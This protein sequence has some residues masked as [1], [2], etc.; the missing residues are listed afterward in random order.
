MHPSYLKCSCDETVNHLSCNYIV[1]QKA[2]AN[3]DVSDNLSAPEGG[4][5]A[6]MQAV[7]CKQQIGWR[8]QAR[9]LLVVSADAGFHYAQDRKVNT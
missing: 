7:V 3:A 9:K 6:I 1:P 4:L 2:V 5:D 8:D